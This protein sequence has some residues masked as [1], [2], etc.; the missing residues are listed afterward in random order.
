GT[1]IAGSSFL[2]QIDGITGHVSTSSEAAFI[3]SGTTVNF[4]NVNVT[5][6]PG[7]FTGQYFVPPGSN[8]PLTGPRTMVLVPTLVYALDNGSTIAGSSFQFTVDGAGNVSP[9]SAAAVGVGHV[10]RLENVVVSV[11]P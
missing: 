3:S 4:N 6:D 10:L 5:I 11:D 7:N 8:V 9:S 1:N 2:I